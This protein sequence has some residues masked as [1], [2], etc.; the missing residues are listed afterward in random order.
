VESPLAI[1]A[2][3]GHERRP[4]SGRTPE[5]LGW[6]GP[7]HTVVS[8]PGP[9]EAAWIARFG[10]IATV[11]RVLGGGVSL[12]VVST[13]LE[14]VRPDSP[15]VVLLHGRGHA[16]TLWLPILA[17]LAPR[18]RVTAIDLP[19]FGHSGWVDPVDGLPE[20]ALR[21]FAE[22]IADAL[23][24]IPA[25]RASP[26]LSGNFLVGHSLGGLVALAAVLR[27]GVRVD[28]LALIGSMGLSTYARPRARLY[29]HAGP[30]RLASL[31]RLWPRRP[32]HR[33]PELAELADVRAELL[34]AHGA[35]RAKAA[36]D[37]MLPL[38]GPV[39]SLEAELGKLDLP[40]LLLWGERDEAF[41]LPVA[42]KAQG[43][44]RGAELS[45]MDTGHSPHLERPHR[46]AESLDRF[47]SGVKLHEGLTPVRAASR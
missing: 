35:D 16:A 6:R 32:S 31:G 33:D 12:R 20:S 23:S 45:V 38:F 9:R 21:S 36:F 7:I 14:A 30:E 2:D 47:F 8:T 34:T 46:V 10:E 43:L 15:H 39:V 11:R 28:G 26:N 27:F 5:D 22:P 19:G 41:P 13:R 44:I 25:L 3:P 40:T 18:Y 29:L 1:D 24:T 42:M 37:A 4:M 17:S